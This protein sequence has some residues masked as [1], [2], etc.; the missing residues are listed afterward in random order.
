[1]SEIVGLTMANMKLAGSRPYIHV[2]AAIAKRHKARKIPLWWDAGTLATIEAW[3]AERAAQGAT[4]ESPFLCHHHKGLQGRPLSVRTAQARF[5]TCIKLLG[6][7]RQ[8]LLSIH[9]GRHS[10]C[11][12]A[13]AGG[14]SLAEVRDAAG[15]SNISTTSIYLHAVHDDDEQVGNLF[16]FTHR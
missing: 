12:H 10:F 8:Q 1:V 15:H 13:I 3:K 16:D 14:R 2:P 6:K 7:E 5:K 9:S 4:G 11:S